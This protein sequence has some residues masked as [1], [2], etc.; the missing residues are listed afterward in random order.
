[1]T[2]LHVLILEDDPLDAELEIATL[3]KAGYECLW[4]RVETRLEFL[5]QLETKH[6]DLILAD[7][8]LPTFDG[9][10]ALRLILERQVETPFI[11]ISGV[12]GEETALE[13]LKAGATDYV[14]KERLSRLVPVAKRALHEKEEQRQ[15]KQAEQALRE[16]EKRYRTLFE[17]AGDAIF[18]SEAE[19]E[20]AGKILAANQAAA[21]MYG[22]TVSELQAMNL[23]DLDP[24]E[25][26][27]GIFDRMP[28][29]LEG[30]WIIAEIIHRKQDGTLFPVEISAGLLELGQAKV[31]FAFY[32]DITERKKSEQAL[33]ESEERYRAVVE[34]LPAMI[35]RFLPDGTLTF[36]NRAYSAFLNKGHQTPIGQ[37][38][39]GLLP[40]AEQKRIRI[41]LLSL[42]PQNPNKTYEH[43]MITPDGQ[44]LWLEWNDRALFD[45][46]G[47]VVEYQSI[48][49]DITENK[50]ALKERE[51]MEKL[52]QEAQKLEAIGTLA[53][54]IAHDFNN[55]LSAIIG[56]AG[57]M[58]LAE[59]PQ[60]SPL[61]PYLEGI[62]RAGDRAKDLVSQIL[63]FSQDNEKEK[64]PVQLGFIIKE[65]LKFLRA[66]LPSTI[67][68]HQDFSKETGTILA[69]A[70]QMH[71][72][73]MNLCTNAAQAMRDTGGSLDVELA[74]VILDAQEAAHLPG[75]KAG[76]YVRLS[77]KDSGHGMSPEILERIFEPYFTTKAKG[78][79]TGL[80][81]AVTH[82]IV[83]NHEGAIYVKSE[84]GKGSLFEVYLPVYESVEF[85]VRP[86]APEPLPQGTERVLFVDDEPA[87]LEIGKK[88][89]KRLGYQVDVR[90][91]SLE[92]LEVFRAKPDEYD[93]VITDLTM[94]NMTGD[95]L[96]REI[97]AVRSD[98]PIILSTGFSQVVTRERAKSM[99]IKE[100]VMKP[101]T[102]RNLAE[103]VRKV[104]DGSNREDVRYT[105]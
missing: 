14:L 83:K 84:L 62:L 102:V 28:W 7:F 53:G 72:V 41:Y 86:V 36:M 80:G 63:T 89:L 44:A 17:M 31:I 27:K 103:T 66:S 13:A 60:D 38:I 105:V 52:L 100:L 70:T 58:Q 15:R 49:R 30:E 79:G 91:S 73:L 56:Y 19:G 35:F 18:M 74:E 54:G 61:G 23:S 94:P 26:A 92:A 46:E 78:E 47:K 64:R 104:L 65:V 76:P 69:N 51:K 93:L 10:T 25:G 45:Q 57:L 42:D 50:Q 32:R 33:L 95:R 82:G 34:G 90:T 21:L 3:E 24:P 9:M 85:E 4:D 71:Q 99:G 8:N 6:Y 12:M 97:L 2:Q 81:L 11:I 68:I 96:A 77:V 101:L 88:I 98:I 75:L 29:L 16:S 20:D 37:N 55:I 67:K 40:E 59:I 22:Y 39:F 1:V 5:S 43:E 87:I 48:G